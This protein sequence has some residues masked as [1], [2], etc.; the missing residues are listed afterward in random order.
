MI[1]DGPLPL[2]QPS[3]DFDAEEDSTDVSTKYYWYGYAVLALS[4]T[5]F[6]VTANSVFLCWKFVIEPLSWSEN[7]RNSYEYL[8]SVFVTVDDY[9]VSLWGVYVV[10]WWWAVFSWIGL[11]MFKQSKGT[12]T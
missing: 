12:Q 4:W 10:A 8:H 5:I 1:Q 3:A 7:T 9:V 6:I 11:K 2:I